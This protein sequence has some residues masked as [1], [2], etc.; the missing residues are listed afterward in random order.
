MGIS[1]N[2]PP[3]ETEQLKRGNSFMSRRKPLILRLMR[4]C[5]NLNIR[6]FVIFGV[7]IF[8]LGTKNTHI[9]YI[10]FKEYSILYYV[11]PPSP[12]SKPGLLLHPRCMPS[13]H[14]RTVIPND[15][16]AQ[17]SLIIGDFDPVLVE[18]S[19]FRAIISCWGSLPERPCSST[20]SHRLVSSSQRIGGSKWS[21]EIITYL[22]LS[23][24][25][26]SRKSYNNP[27]RLKSTKS[28]TKL[29]MKPPTELPRKL[30]TKS[31]TELPKKLPKIKNYLKKGQEIE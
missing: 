22:H 7:A 27:P 18:I 11:Y 28:P 25:T 31:S 26:K 30:P 8:V 24:V 9:I 21:K 29:P 2:L 4:N 13:W 5:L 10:V 23:G 20:K 3:V 16:A 19:S 1:S 14:E 6:D 17:N 15:R 12:L